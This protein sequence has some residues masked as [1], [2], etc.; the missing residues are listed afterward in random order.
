M[1]DAPDMETKVNWFIAGF[2]LAPIALHE[3]SGDVPG[4]LL[5]FNIAPPG[6]PPGA[7]AA[8]TGPMGITDAALRELLGGLQDRL[9]QWDEFQAKGRSSGTVQ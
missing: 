9:R 8:Q 6:S 5:S 2:V 3:P 1:S 4:W 7:V